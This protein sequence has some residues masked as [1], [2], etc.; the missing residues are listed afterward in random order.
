MGPA[1][2]GPDHGSAAQVPESSGTPPHP[3]HS[4]TSW[5]PGRIVSAIVGAVFALTALGPLTA[6]GGLLFADTTQRDADGYLSAAFDTRSDG[7][8]IA[9][10]SIYV[11]GADVRWLRTPDVLGD[12]RLSATS[13]D[14][15]KSVFIGI[16]PTRAATAYLADIGHTQSSNAFAPADGAVN[17][18]GGA[19]EVLPGDSDIW[20]ARSSGMGTQSVNW[21]VSDGDWTVVVMNNDGTRPVLVRAE[22]GATLPALPWIATA[23]L[24]AGAL[25]L[26]IG[27]TLIAMAVRR[28]TH[29]PP[30]A[31]SRVP[32]A[33]PF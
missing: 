4:P 25:F 2:R 21:D 33:V 1:T 7:Y 18:P 20:A 30:P 16:A 32:E 14:P 24:I 26:V 13:T 23:M 17:R 8:A 27:A 10:E 9:T 11:Q 28:A 19:P 6:G 3:V 5:T 22:V 15:A 12:V 31:D 29:R